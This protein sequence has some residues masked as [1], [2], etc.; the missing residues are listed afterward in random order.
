MR[1]IALHDT[2]SL[3]Q[4][5]SCCSLLSFSLAT[6]GYLTSDSEWYFMLCYEEFLSRG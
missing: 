3:R 6:F 2:Y 5:R 4:L 1:L